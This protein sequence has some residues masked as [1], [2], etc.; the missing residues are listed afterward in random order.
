MDYS[1]VRYG[2]LKGR[3]VVITGGASGIGA[4][5]VRAFCQQEAEVSFLDIDEDSGVAIGAV[6]GASFHPCDL[7]D[8]PDACVDSPVVLWGE[9]MPAD[10]VATAA[11]TISYEMFCALARRVPIIES[12]GN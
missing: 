1:T 6:T 11:G 8:I 5:L 9:G 12:N 3:H 10:E 2:S 7:T 4:E